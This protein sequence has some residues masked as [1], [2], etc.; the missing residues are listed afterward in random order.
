M[1]WTILMGMAGSA[2][3]LN[4]YRTR[5]PEASNAVPEAGESPACWS[6][7]VANPAVLSASF[8]LDCATTALERRDY[9][10]ARVLAE[11]ALSMLETAH[12]SERQRL[13]ARRVLREALWPGMHHT[14]LVA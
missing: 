1:I 9:G 4:A 5:G 3:L 12:A 11:K 2:W 6:P 7:R 10:R 8:V 14:D 13:V